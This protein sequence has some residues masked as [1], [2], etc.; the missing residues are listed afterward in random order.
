[1]NEREYQPV[2][3]CQY[4]WSLFPQPMTREPEHDDRN[5]TTKSTIVRC[6]AM[7]CPSIRILSGRNLQKLTTVMGP[8]TLNVVSLI[9]IRGP[10]HPTPRGND[11]VWGWGPKKESH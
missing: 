10:H 4:E 9:R 11:G 6:L 5:Q 7:S 3:N 2:A 8:K 1:M